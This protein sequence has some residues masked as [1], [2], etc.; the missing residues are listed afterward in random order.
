MYIILSDSCYNGT[1]VWG[2]I[3]SVMPLDVL[4]C[5]RA[6]MKTGKKV[7]TGRFG[8][9]MKVSLINDGPVTINID[10]KNKE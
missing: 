8:A 7:K 10:T 2:N 6:T 1:E 5:T 9:D 4:C 3:R